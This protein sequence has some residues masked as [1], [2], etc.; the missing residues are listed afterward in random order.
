[1]EPLSKEDIDR[2]DG[3]YSGRIAP[4]L[5]KR[6]IYTARLGAEFIKAT[7]PLTRDSIGE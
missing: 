1:M 2:I 6:L 5:W 3:V 7:T 4:E